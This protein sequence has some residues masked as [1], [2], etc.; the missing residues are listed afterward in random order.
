MNVLPWSGIS[1]LVK[2]RSVINLFIFHS[3]LLSTSNFSKKKKKSKPKSIKNNTAKQNRWE[4]RE[5]AGWERSLPPSL[6]T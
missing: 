6:A 3:V 4:A 1:I 2:A 5:R